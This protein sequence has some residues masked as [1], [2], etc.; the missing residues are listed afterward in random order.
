VKPMDE[1]RRGAER[2][3]ARLTTMLKNLDTGRIL[4]VLTRDLSTKGMCVVTEGLLSAGTRL[5]VELKMPDRETPLTVQAEVAWS[6]V[7]D[8][9]RKSY[10]SPTA[11]TGIAFTNLS[12]HALALIKHC[13]A[14]YGLS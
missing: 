4:R 2:A 7:I 10:E 6:R 9:P 8:E 13:A 1:E 12:P 14:F 11:E 5:E 3:K